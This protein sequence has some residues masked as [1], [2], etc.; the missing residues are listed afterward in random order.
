M[1]PT[2]FRKISIPIPEGKLDPAETEVEQ[3]LRDCTSISGALKTVFDYH[4]KFQ[5][6]YPTGQEHDL[7]AVMLR[8]ARDDQLED[9]VQLYSKHRHR[10]IPP[11]TGNSFVL[12]QLALLSDCLYDLY[13][14][15]AGRM[16]ITYLKDPPERAPN[17]LEEAIKNAPH[18]F[19]L[20]HV[21]NFVV[22]DNSLKLASTDYFHSEQTL[23]L[24]IPT[25]GQTVL[26]HPKPA[27]IHAVLNHRSGHYRPDL[28][29]LERA[30]NLMSG[31]I[32]KLGFKPVIEFTDQYLEHYL[33]ANPG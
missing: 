27:E 32:H 14:R 21:F 7:W 25:G 23:G 18:D 4:E 24:P 3:A 12:Y 15:E 26:C 13:A 20:E 11:D 8:D 6:R 31:A 17:I 2:A 16:P 28:S 1:P 33:G 30:G 29:S 22:Q 5:E 19:S 10:V 9:A